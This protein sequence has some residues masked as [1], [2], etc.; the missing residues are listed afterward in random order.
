MKEPHAR[1]RRL[2]RAKLML[3]V[4]TA[5]ILPNH[6]QCSRL[7]EDGVSA[8]ITSFVSDVTF[9]L[10]TTFLRP[11]DLF[12]DGTGNGNDNSNTN[13]DPFEPPVQG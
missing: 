9:D 12:G 1:L 2:R 6:L 5:G 7:V 10:L 4:A 11:F 13:G 8:G 3:A